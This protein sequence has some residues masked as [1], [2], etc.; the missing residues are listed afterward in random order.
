M[1]HKDDTNMEISSLFHAQRIQFYVVV[2]C[3]CLD[4]APWHGTHHF[5][6]RKKQLMSHF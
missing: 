4:S 2:I 6:E 3:D 5:A 1:P